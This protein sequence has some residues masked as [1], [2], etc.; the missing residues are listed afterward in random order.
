[1]EAW[2]KTQRPIYDHEPQNGEEMSLSRVG[3][4][5]YERVISYLIPTD[6][7]F[8]FEKFYFRIENYQKDALT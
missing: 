1:M 2:L 8:L 3:K 6:N 7:L 5:L 4:E